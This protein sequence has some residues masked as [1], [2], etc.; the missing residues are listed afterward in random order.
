[1]EHPTADRAT[2]LLAAGAIGSAG[3][4]F[5]VVYATSIGHGFF[6]DDFAWIVRSRVHDVTGW[7]DLF[8]T[9]NGFYRPLVAVSFAANYAF[10]GNRPLGYGLT[11]LAVAVLCAVLIHRLLRSLEFPHGAAAFGAFVWLLNFHG[12][13]MAI[14][15]T[16][17]RT[18][19]LVVAAS[20]ATAIA[21]L[22]RRVVLSVLCLLAALFSKE[23]AVMLPVVLAS[24]QLLLRRERRGS[25]HHLVSFALG[26]AIAF[27]IYFA[28][29]VQSDAMTYA[30][31]PPYY[32]PTFDPAHVL[33]NSRE[34][35]DRTFTFPVA[36]TVFAFL[37]LRPRSATAIRWDVLKCGLGWVAGGF[38]LTLFVPG[39]SNIYVCLPS[40]GSAL[41]AATVCSSFWNE[42]SR[43][44]R[45]RAL[46]AAILI[47]LA[48]APIYIARNRR[49]VDLAEFTARTLADMASLTGDLPADTPVVVVDD[50]SSRANLLSAFGTLLDDA[51]ELQTGRRLRIW[52]EPAIDDAEESGMS[53]PCTGCERRRLAVRNGRV[54]L[55]E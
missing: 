29:R 3:L 40:V 48:C 32:Q 42:A 1:M 44:A 37:I 54:V 12:I 33:R 30:T 4:V 18:A 55:D 52:V 47:P 9:N 27:T 51:Y 7:P 53:R 39:R 35:A 26:A 34:Y 11:N 28:L 2:Q 46:I 14:I 41:I 36:L 23:E 8:L 49:Y 50:R 45:K 5:V 31:A 43:E 10:F 19:L 22:E 25:T 20:V 13:N 38:A 6:T 17:G 24:W 21:T 15:W 16:S